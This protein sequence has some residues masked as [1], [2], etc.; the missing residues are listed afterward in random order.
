MR[1]LFIF[2]FLV[3]ISLF[4]RDYYQIQWIDTLDVNDGYD[5]GYDVVVDK[6]NN[7]YVTGIGDFETSLGRNNFLTIKY[8]SLGTIQLMDTLDNGGGEWATGIA[9]DSSGNVY[10]TGRSGIG[11]DSGDFLTVKYNSDL[12]IQWIDTFGF[13]SLDWARD[14]AIDK[15]GNV[16]VTGFS[17]NVP[18]KIN[19]LTI[20]YDSSGTIQWFD[21]LDISGNDQA[22]G[23]AVDDN[24]NVYVTGESQIGSSCDMLTLKYDSGGIVLR[25]DTLDNGLWDGGYGIVVD[26]EG[27]IYITG[28]SFLYGWDYIFTVKYD[29]L[30]VIRWTDSVHISS[31]NCGDDIAVDRAGNVYVVGNFDDCW[32]EEGS[33]A[34]I[35]YDSE[36]SIQWINTFSTDSLSA[37][38]NGIAV[39]NADNIYITGILY[40]HPDIIRGYLGSDY[41]TIKYLKTVGID[42]AIAFDGAIQETGIDDDDYVVLYFSEETNKP[43]ISNSTIDSVLFLSFSHSWLDGSGNIESA[44]WNVEGTE[45]T[46]NLSTASSVP[47]IEIGDTIRPDGITIENQRGGT[48]SSPVILQGSFEESGEEETNIILELNVPPVNAGSISLSYTVDG[49]G[50]FSVRIYGIDG[51][52]AKEIKEENGGNYVNTITDISSGTYF[53]ELKK[54][55]DILKKK[56]VLLR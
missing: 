51:R 38:A 52:I 37:E 53:F 10:V 5:G 4:A 14:I 3:V 1:K 22:Y 2:I 40:T 41:L 6:E 24:G 31:C 32:G 12:E 54:G 45:L 50:P 7:I 34:T 8:D 43:V 44:I 18:S 42:S 17:E 33:F 13:D 35:K 25:I 47:T 55:N 46:I 27:N 29:S 15:D 39:D 30:G 9:I 48:C 36:G 26:G 21:T 16:Y 28:H 19:Y 56:A 11:Y 49:D 23:I 20:K